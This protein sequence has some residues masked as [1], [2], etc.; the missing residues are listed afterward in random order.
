MHSSINSTDQ[1]KEFSV[2]ENVI[3]IKYG[4]MGIISGM[5]DFYEMNNTKPCCV[6]LAGANFSLTVYFRSIAHLFKSEHD[7]I[8]YLKENIQIGRNAQ[9]NQKEVVVVG[10]EKE[11]LTPQDYEILRVQLERESGVPLV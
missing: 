2:L 11:Q 10:L 6:N 5:V 1:V 4:D 9:S 8:N 7:F 3:V